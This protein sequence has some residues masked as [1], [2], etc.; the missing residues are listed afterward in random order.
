MQDLQTKQITKQNLS[1]S[2][3]IFNQW[4]E[5]KRFVILILSNL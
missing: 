3:K 1:M 2:Q 5:L 4:F